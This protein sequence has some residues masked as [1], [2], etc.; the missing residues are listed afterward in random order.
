M[1]LIIKGSAKDV[2]KILQAIG[3][4]QEHY[5]KKALID[6]ESA[7]SSLESLAKALWAIQKDHKPVDFNNVFSKLGNTKT[8]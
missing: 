5:E 4:S 8:N 1:E 6:M 3:S 7:K 2:K